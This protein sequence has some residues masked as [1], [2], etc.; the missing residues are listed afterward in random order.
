MVTILFRNVCLRLKVVGMQTTT[1]T[2]H[3]PWKRWVPF[4]SEIFSFAEQSLLT[5]YGGTLDIG[6]KFGGTSNGLIFIAVSLK[7]VSKLKSSKW[8]IEK[9]THACTHRSFIP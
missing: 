4:S 1:E 3:M 8:D 2:V 9:H 7:P 5:L 6:K